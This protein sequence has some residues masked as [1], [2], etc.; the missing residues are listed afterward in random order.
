MRKLLLPLLLSL[1]L[2]TGC[3]FQRKPQPGPTPQLPPPRDPVVTPPI[4][5]PEVKTEEEPLEQSPPEV[6]TPKIVTPPAQPVKVE[7]PPPRRRPRPAAV[8]PAPEPAPPPA[9]TPAAPSE[10]PSSGTPAQAP[11]LGEVLGDDQRAAYTAQIT[12][13]LA[14]ARQS[15]ESLRGKNLNKAQ[16][17]DAARVRGFISQ[18]EALKLSD[19]RSAA[20]LARR[21][22]LLAEDLAS[23]VQ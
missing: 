18:A 21:A 9:P 3:P 7:E 2:L 1:V 10:A 19:L 13:A 5:V 6:S 17:D 20:Q 22:A 16:Q 8:K 14:S 15:L 12:G 23:S 4:Q 11:Q